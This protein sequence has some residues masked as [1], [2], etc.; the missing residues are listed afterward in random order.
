LACLHAQICQNA[1]D[2]SKFGLTMVPSPEEKYILG[3]FQN[4]STDQHYKV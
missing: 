3:L 4:R 2:I 1:D